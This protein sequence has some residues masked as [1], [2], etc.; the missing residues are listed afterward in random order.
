LVSLWLEGFAI[1]SG[2]LQLAKRTCLASVLVAHVL[3]AQTTDEANRAAKRLAAVPAAPAPYVPITQ[4]ER[5]AYYAHHLFNVESLF[6]T[7][8][9]AGINQAMDTP[10][11]WGEGAEGYGRRFASIYGEH[12]VQAT[13]M[14]GT[15]IVFREDN[16]YFRSGESSFGSRFKYAVESTLVARHNDGSRHLSISRVSSYLAAAAISRLWQPPSTRGALHGLNLFGIAVGVEA[17]FNVTRE[18]LPG[19]FHA[20]APVISQNPA[21]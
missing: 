4:K 1:M 12:V 9:G 8:A 17:G 3:T 11:E 5:L 19:I 18:F 7:A 14:Y 10:H 15:S 16:R 13:V 6:R 20:R 21:H 2:V